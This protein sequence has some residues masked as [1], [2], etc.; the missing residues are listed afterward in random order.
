M[1][2]PRTKEQAAK[3]QAE[4]KPTKDDLHEQRER[5][6]QQEG[7]VHPNTPKAPLPQK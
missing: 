3:Q 1:N 4:H 2:D 5:E 7:A 6:Q